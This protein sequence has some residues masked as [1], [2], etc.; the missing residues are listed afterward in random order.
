MCESR[1]CTIVAKL[2]VLLRDFCGR[3]WISRRGEALLSGA[4]CAGFY[5]IA[6]RLDGVSHY[7]ELEKP[8]LDDSE[9]GL[10]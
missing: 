3:G 9:L 5:P 4:L 7:W 1:S 2:C 8:E 10:V 6:D